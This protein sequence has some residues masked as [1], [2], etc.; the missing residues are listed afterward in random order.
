MLNCGLGAIGMLALSVLM[1]IFDDYVLAFYPLFNSNDVLLL[2]FTAGVMLMASTSYITAPSISLE[3]KNLWIYHSL[4]ITAWQ[5]FKAKIKLQV[6]V[7]IIPVIAFITV[8]A[9][10]V[11]ASAIISILC[12]LCAIAY[13]IVHAEF[14]LIINLK[15]PN[16]NWR[17]ETVPVKQSL[18]VILALFG[19]WLI[20]FALVGLYI[21]I[22]AHVTPITYILI[23]LSIVITLGLLLWYLLKF[24]CEKIFNNL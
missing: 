9:I 24:K 16:F 8:G 18:S 19:G 4:P 13:I 5:V 10:I 14:G 11:K 20:T 1:A 23:A 21:L 12:A 22:D 3:G 7:L 6:Y 2:L 17:T 15:F